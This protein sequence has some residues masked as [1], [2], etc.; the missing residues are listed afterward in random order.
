[1]P[2]LTK[3]SLLCISLAFACMVQATLAAPVVA[4]AAV[5]DSEALEQLILR[6]KQLKQLS[7]G[8][9]WRTVL[10]VTEFSEF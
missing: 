9:A 4:D 7:E 3:I 5:H 1:M 10:V 6:L 8:K 2:E